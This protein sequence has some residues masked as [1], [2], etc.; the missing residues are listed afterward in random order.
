MKYEYQPLHIHSL[1]F[2]PQVSTERPREREAQKMP[3]NWND[4]EEGLIGKKGV[5]A[6][7]DDFQFVSLSSKPTKK[8]NV[9]HQKAILYYGN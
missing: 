3:R 1:K 9:E 7:C 6:L 5:V 8:S 4:T 2:C